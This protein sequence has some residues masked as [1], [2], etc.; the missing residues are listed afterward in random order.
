HQRFLARRPKR[1]KRDS[2]RKRGELLPLQATHAASDSFLVLITP[3]YAI[4]VPPSVLGEMD[5]WMLE[6]GLNG[7]HGTAIQLPSRRGGRAKRGTLA[8]IWSGL[9]RAAWRNAHIRDFCCR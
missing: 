6:R 9:G 8:G 1:D 5:G 3:E 7:L 4:Q 2:N